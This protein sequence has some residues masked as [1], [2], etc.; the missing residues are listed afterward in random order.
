MSIDDEFWLLFGDRT[1]QDLEHTAQKSP[2]AGRHLAS[3]KLCAY[4]QIMLSTT[5]IQLSWK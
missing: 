3:G 5:G 2:C 4:E 1:L